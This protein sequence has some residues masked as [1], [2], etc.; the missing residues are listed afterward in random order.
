M[1]PL[2]A[3]KLLRQEVASESPLGKA[4]TVLLEDAELQN[5]R[6]SARTN[7]PYATAIICGRGQGINSIL[8]RITPTQDPAQQGRGVPVAAGAPR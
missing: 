6:Q 5:Y 4:L 8:N 7:D 3:E 1:T 2:E